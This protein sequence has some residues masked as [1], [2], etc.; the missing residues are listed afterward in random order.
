M[1]R[2]FIAARIAKTP[3]LIHLYRRLTRLDDSFR[4]VP[5]DNLHL[6][7]KFL[8]PTEQ[9]KLDEIAAVTRAIAARHPAHTVALHGLGAFPNARRPAVV[10]IGIQNGETLCSIAAALESELAAFGFMPES[11]P[12]LPHL[13]L[14]RVKTRLPESLFALLEE[15]SEKD[16]G[17]APIASVEFFQSELQRGGSRYS[18]LASAPLAAE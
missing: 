13:T 7:L 12:F 14:L 3:E 10:W 11:R 9:E 15:W 8:G 4:P 2:T 5:I 18:V 1:L 16:F 6:T 17:T